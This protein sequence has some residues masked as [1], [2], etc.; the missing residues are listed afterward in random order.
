M[1]E[2][3]PLGGRGPLQEAKEDA[4]QDGAAGRRAAVRG[5]GLDVWQIVDTVQDGGGPREDAIDEMA[6]SLEL[7]PAQIR[8]ALCY[9]AAYPEEINAQIRLNDDLA[10]E[11]ELAWLRQQGLPTR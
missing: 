5:T 4:C 10:A 2:E 1:R 8:V 7:T 6:V 3:A 11:L 9:Y